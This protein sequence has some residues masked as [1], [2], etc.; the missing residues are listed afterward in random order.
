MD[1]G[2]GSCGAN[3]GERGGG[4]IGAR[5]GLLKIVGGLPLGGGGGDLRPPRCTTTLNIEEEKTC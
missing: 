1:G 2:E 5:G 3:G 4:R